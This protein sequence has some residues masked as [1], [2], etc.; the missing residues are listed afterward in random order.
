MAQELFH[1]T[2]SC[3][4]PRIIRSGELRPAVYPAG[5]PPDFVHA[6]TNENGERTAAGWGMWEE[7]YR[8]GRLRRVRFT[9][10]AEDFEPWREVCARFP[11]W[12][13]ALIESLEK[14]GRERGSSPSAWFC[15]VEPLPLA[16]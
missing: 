15:R 11:R 13:A 7:D 10:A 1:F 9:L 4:L 8:S 12:E 16:K 2:T 14:T 5:Q 3:H 6:T